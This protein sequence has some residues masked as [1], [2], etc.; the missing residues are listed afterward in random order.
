MWPEVIY[1][2]NYNGSSTVFGSANYTTTNGDPTSNDYRA[3]LSYFNF[4]LNGTSSYLMRQG[5]TVCGKPVRRLAVMSL[6]D[7]TNYVNASDFRAIGGTYHDTGMIWGVRLL[8]R[9]GIFAS[10]NGSWPNRQPPNRV[11][12]FLTDGDMA[13][14]LNTYGMYGIEYFDKRVTGGNYSS[15][16]D[17]HN[18]RFLAECA[19]AK[20]MNISV[21]TVSIAPSATT[22]MQQCATTSSQSLFTTDGGDLS[23]KFAAIAK[24]VAMLRISQ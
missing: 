10:D 1:G 7:V 12:V 17:Y 3:A 13:P 6:N 21:W 19:K 23:D 15:Q 11:I 14:T 24:Q 8:S 20:A 4:S 22:Q 16:E 18:A 9:L 2:R 5:W